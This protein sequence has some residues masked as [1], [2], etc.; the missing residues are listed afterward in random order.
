M[1]DPSTMAPVPSEDIPPL[2]NARFDASGVS[3]PDG[4]VVVAG[5]L[6]VDMLRFRL[7]IRIGNRIFKSDLQPFLDLEQ[8]S[9][10]GFTPWNV[11][12]NDIFMTKL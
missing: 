12:P 8:S 1:L 2:R 3:L 6:R 9:G 5:G 11:G 10:M 4:R 7:R